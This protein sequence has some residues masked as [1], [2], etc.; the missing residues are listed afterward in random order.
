METVDLG[1]QSISAYKNEEAA[2]QEIK[3]L[4]EEYIVEKT[5]EL[6]KGG[7]THERAVKWA[8]DYATRQYYVEE[9]EL[10]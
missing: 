1:G 7:Y 5:K 9:T 3:V 10:I 4:T 2:N 8:N 6:I